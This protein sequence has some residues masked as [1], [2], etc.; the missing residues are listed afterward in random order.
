[1][2]E[3]LKDKLSFNLLTAHLFRYIKLV[4]RFGLRQLVDMASNFFDN[5]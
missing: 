1:M 3:I 5:H 4:T 2:S